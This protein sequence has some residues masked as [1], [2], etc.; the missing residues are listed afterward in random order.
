[1][2]YSLC[3]LCQVKE[4]CCTYTEIVCVFFDFSSRSMQWHSLCA[5][6]GDNVSSASLSC[7]HRP[8]GLNCVDG[9]GQFILGDKA[10][11]VA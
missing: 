9:F 11:E 10:A 4:I 7:F 3:S 8:V 5:I 1:M 2:F 6:V